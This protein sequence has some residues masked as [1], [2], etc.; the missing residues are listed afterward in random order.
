MH[1]GAHSRRSNLA[2]LVKVGRVWP[3]VRQGGYGW[4]SWQSACRLVFGESYEDRR[5]AA[6]RLS[7]SFGSRAASDTGGRDG[8]DPK[9]RRACSANHLGARATD[10]WMDE[11]SGAGMDSEPVE[12]R[13]LQPAA[14]RRCEPGDADS[15]RRWRRHSATLPRGLFAGGFTG[16]QCE[17]GGCHSLPV[18]HDDPRAVRSKRP[19]KLI[20]PKSRAL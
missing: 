6:L 10:P 11:G 19:P 13:R 9:R 3:P 12:R 2:N 14:G 7:V 5:D 4:L 16:R 18:P 8:A 15:K 1:S 17:C 20:G